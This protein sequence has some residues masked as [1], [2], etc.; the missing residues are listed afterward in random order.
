MTRFALDTNLYIDWW[1][2]APGSED[3]EPFV[4]AHAPRLYLA[5]IVAQELLAGAR[6]AEAVQRLHTLILAPFERRGRLLTPTHEAWKQSGR[7]VAQCAAQT[8]EIR[9]SFWNDALL[10]A[11]CREQG[12]TL[13]TKNVQDFA[14]IAAVHPFRYVEPWP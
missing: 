8:P 10:A 3:L 14:R 11:T 9:T 2:T 6:T 7:V 12:V 1:R 5:S 13:I 4:E